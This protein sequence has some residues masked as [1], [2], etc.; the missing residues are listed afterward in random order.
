MF[1]I[2]DM[3]LLGLM[4]TVLYVCPYLS[5][6]HDPDERRL[7]VHFPVVVAVGGLGGACS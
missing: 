3:S 5:L 6:F 2:D 7:Q 1:N 4:V